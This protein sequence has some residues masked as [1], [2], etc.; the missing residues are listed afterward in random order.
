M[1]RMFKQRT[2]M[3]AAAALL[4]LIL[5]LLFAFSSC[6]GDEKDTTSTEPPTPESFEP[7]VEPTPTV[8][9][10][11]VLIGTAVDI[12]TSLNIRAEPNTDSA[13][14]G[15]AKNGDSF[16]VLEANVDGSDWHKISY[17]GMVAYVSSKYLVVDTIQREVVPSASPD[18]AT[19]DADDPEAP[20]LNVG[21]GQ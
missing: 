15:K 12:D 2:V 21:D 11:D 18:V 14:L 13:I 1:L 5:I 4:V 17:E 8:Q 9:Y 3:I 7:T 19:P 20:G 16:T 10:E 6:G